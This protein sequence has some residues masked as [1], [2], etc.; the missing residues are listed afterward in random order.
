MLSIVC[1][2]YL[3]FDA[4]VISLNFKPSK[5]E[6]LT[7]QGSNRKEKKML[8]IIF[9]ESTFLFS[10]SKMRRHEVL[11]SILVPSSS[12]VISQKQDRFKDM[13][14][15]SEVAGKTALP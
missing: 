2:V 12:K 4:T 5:Y 13:I 3:N 11:R 7:F 9:T 8:Y 10:R 6:V 14:N 15:G 1:I